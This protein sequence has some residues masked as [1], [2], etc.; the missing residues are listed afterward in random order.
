MSGTTSTPSPQANRLQEAALAME[1]EYLAVK[2]LKRLS[3]GNSLLFDP[4]LPQGDDPEA[5]QA[6][7][8]S[9]SSR[10]NSS[11]S[12]YTPS[13]TGSEELANADGNDYIDY[14]DDF[15][16][17]DPDSSLTDSDI[18]VPANA[19]PKLAPENFRRH[20]EQQVMQIQN[21]SK[22]QRSGSVKSSLGRERKLEDNSTPLRTSSTSS[23]KSYIDAV[24]GI[25]SPDNSPSKWSRKP[26]LRE[27][28]VQLESLSHIAGLDNND[29]ASLARTLST[30]SIGISNVEKQAFSDGSFPR[31]TQG[32]VNASHRESLILTE[33]SVEPI[34]QQTYNHAYKDI[35]KIHRSVPNRSQ[36]SHKPSS[37]L[38]DVPKSPKHNQHS[39]SPQIQQRSPSSPQIQQRSPSSP[40]LQQ[41]SPSSPSLQQRSPSSP[42][43][44]QGPHGAPYQRSPSS[45]SLGQQ[46]YQNQYQNQYYQQQYYPMGYPQNGY[47]HHPQQ[48]PHWAPSGYSNGQVPMPN[49]SQGH[50]GP[51]GQ[52]VGYSKGYGADPRGQPRNRQRHRDHRDHREFHSNKNKHRLHRQQVANAYPP[53]QQQ[54]HYQQM[55]Y[56]QQK[57]QRPQQGFSP[58]SSPLPRQRPRIKKQ[59]LPPLQTSARPQPSHLSE[60]P[61]NGTFN[62]SSSQGS[63]VTPTPKDRMDSLT[64]DL[65]KASLES[66]DLKV[67]TEQEIAAD[68]EPLETPT[69]VSKHVTPPLLDVESVVKPKQVKPKER[70]SSFT[71]FF[72]FKSRNTSA[73]QANH[74]E[75]VLETPPAS[76]DSESSDKAD[77]VY[78]SASG[79]FK[80]L[81]TGKKPKAVEP[82]KE[83]EKDDLNS[84]SLSSFGLRKKSSIDNLVRKKASQT[85]LA[86]VAP[87][88]PE[89]D[90]SL[91]EAASTSPP[92]EETAKQNLTVGTQNHSKLHPSR[93]QP[94]QA[95]PLSPSAMTKSLSKSDEEESEEESNEED[96]DTEPATVPQTPPSEESNGPKLEKVVSVESEKAILEPAE[97]IVMGE[98]LVDEPMDN[99][100]VLEQPTKKDDIVVTNTTVTSSMDETTEIAE[101]EPSRELLKQALMETIRSQKITKPNQPLEMRES[102]FGF[103]LPP[104]STSTIYMVDHRLPVH[105]ERAIYRLSHLK[106]ADSKRQLRQ[107]VLL[108]NF[109]YSYLNLVNHTLWLQKQQEGDISMN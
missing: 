48:H 33:S 40:Q 79:N 101:E 52:H 107:Q 96:M 65:N 41:R 45:P 24:D 10:S 28:T 8:T 11:A 51:T 58:L 25:G 17:L 35:Q 57:Q 72:K 76:A 37:K 97:D 103:P 27:L 18:W 43:L 19:H 56:Q 47:Q 69:S 13:E 81:F 83:S 91:N 66:S 34:Q 14:E 61:I 46:Q 93:D 31:R 63:P 67:E 71:S 94:Y 90:Q 62:D 88:V 30:R 53:Q 70:K 54:M 60:S 42:Q 92:M 36:P 4:D 9:R 12:S 85:P 64:T 55:H 98:P 26:S 105:V 108:S 6:E 68:D 74:E 29:A 99:G 23:A 15:I 78:K 87:A 39:S 22:L 16:D 106:L 32:S 20:V 86:P 82:V 38:P 84:P 100:P 1:E 2:R 59:Q 73:S 89:K 5:Q 102:A 21:K 3:I 77:K 95:Y 104:V 80:S 49:G 44:R 109:M 7:R 75:P 50:L